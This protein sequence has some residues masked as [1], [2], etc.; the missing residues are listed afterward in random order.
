M[1]SDATA[2]PGLNFQIDPS[3][4]NAIH[5]PS[6]DQEGHHGVLLPAGGR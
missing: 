1:I 5:F 3:M 2:S 6:G 4:A